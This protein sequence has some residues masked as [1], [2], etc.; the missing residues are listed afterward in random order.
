MKLKTVFSFCLY[1]CV[2][3][4]LYLKA[5][6]VLLLKDSSDMTLDDIEALAQNEN[7]GDTCVSYLIEV[8]VEEHLS[9]GSK[10]VVQKYGCTN[11]N[12]G[13]CRKGNVYVYYLSNGFVS[14]E[15][16]TE[17]SMCF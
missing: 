3:V 6:A 8:A 11:G 16:K 5:N 1:V 14:E 9:S 10:T 15:D 17:V 7:S 13:L 4:C 12:A 2:A